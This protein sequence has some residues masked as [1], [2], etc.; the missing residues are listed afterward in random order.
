MAALAIVVNWALAEVKL[1][2]IKL[3]IL[4]SVA[5]RVPALA[6]KVTVE[7]K[8][9]LVANKLA[10]LATVVN[11]ALAEVWVVE[12][13]LAALAIEVNTALAPV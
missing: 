7:P 8:L 5:N 11:T 13:K 10:A 9:E 6:V 2:F 12:I 1:V 3:A 4:E